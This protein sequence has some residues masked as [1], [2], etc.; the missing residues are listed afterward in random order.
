MLDRKEHCT[1]MIF[2][3]VIIV[4]KILKSWA[5]PRKGF[6]FIKKSLI[7][8]FFFKKLDLKKKFLR[9]IFQKWSTNLLEIFWFYFVW[10]GEA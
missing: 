4:R 2:F 10:G 9:I 7:F 1:H 8:I 3:Q 5:N 6:S